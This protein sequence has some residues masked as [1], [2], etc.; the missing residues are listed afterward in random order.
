MT[1]LIIAANSVG[2]PIAMK[3]LAVARHVVQRPLSRPH[4]C[5]ALIQMRHPVYSVSAS[6]IICIAKN[7]QCG[8][9]RLALCGAK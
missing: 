8:I 3:A 1:Y 2:L 6:I 5:V 9:H 4:L 7:R